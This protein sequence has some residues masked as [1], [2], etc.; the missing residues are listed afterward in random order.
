MITIQIVPSAKLCQM[1]FFE[2]RKA[3]NL[4]VTIAVRKSCALVILYVFEF[5]R[6]KLSPSF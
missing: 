1:M 6:G 2:P 4:Y 3:D 5:K